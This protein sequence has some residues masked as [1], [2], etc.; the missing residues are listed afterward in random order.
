VAHNTERVALQTFRALPACEPINLISLLGRFYARSA[1]IVWRFNIGARCS[2][3]SIMCRVYD[4][5][6]GLAAD[7]QEYCFTNNFFITGI[8]F[9]GLAADRQE[10]NS[11]AKD[12]YYYCVFFFLLLIKSIFELKQIFSRSASYIHGDE[13]TL[14]FQNCC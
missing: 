7:R 14:V 1:L 5:F 4:T 2:A 11:F 3:E 6:Y 13:L 10:Y 12:Y 9:Y 8:I